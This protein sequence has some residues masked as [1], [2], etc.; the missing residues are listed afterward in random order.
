M[1]LTPAFERLREV[2]ESKICTGCGACVGLD[3]SFSSRMVRDARGVSPEFGSGLSLPEEA[4]YAC[5]GKGI[6]YPELYKRH[7]GALPNDWRVGPVLKFGTGYA[8]DPVIRSKGASGGVL[9]ATLVHL[10]ETGRIDAAILAKQ[11]M[12]APKEASWYIARTPEEIVECAQSVYVPVSMLDSLR[13]FRPDERYAMT[14][15][16]E[17]SASLRV[18]QHSGNK[19]AKQVRYILG[20]YTGTALEPGAIRSLLRSHGVEKEDAILSL[21]WRAGEWPG[22]L[23]VKTASGRVIQSK[24]VYYNYLIPFFVTQTSLQSMDFANEFADLSVGDAWSPRFES[25]GKG[26][27]VIA[28]RSRMMAD[29]FDEMLRQGKIDFRKEDLLEAASMHGHMIDFKKRGGYLRNRWRKLTGRMAPD[30]GLRPTLVGFPRVLIEAFISSV[31]CICR[32]SVSRWVM[33]KIPE[34]FMG[35]LFNR[36]RFLWK[37]ASK[38]AKRKG[39]RDLKMEVYVPS[40]KREK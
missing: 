9:S 3:E 40:W 1:S 24:K 32:T 19:K 2:A 35:K 36:L 26:F 5:P 38:P 37:S 11:G 21:Q 31:F 34:Q 7:Y 13:D 17:Q 30:Y 22:Y 8:S 15:L 4:W 16:P 28:V 14:C 20:P 33:E 27:S 23:E 18:L 6:D 12:P 29:V 25:Q 39:L 10:L